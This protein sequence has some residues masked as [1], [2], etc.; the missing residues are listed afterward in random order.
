MKA[1]IRPNANAELTAYKR[2]QAAQARTAAKEATMRTKIERRE[3]KLI[4]GVHGE[5]MA[6][7][8]AYRFSL[9]MPAARKDLKSR[10]YF[11]P[12]S[13]LRIFLACELVYKRGNERMGL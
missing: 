5:S 4:L 9:T 7:E 2:E 6:S 10:A 13:V 3:A 12:A 8:Y 1:K 11:D